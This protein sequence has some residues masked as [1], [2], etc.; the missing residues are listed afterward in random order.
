MNAVWLILVLAG[1]T[2]FTRSIGHIVV[3]QF[4]SLHPRV[5]AALDAVPAAV[6]TTIVIPPVVGGGLPERI[7]FLIAVMLALLL[8]IILTVSISVTVLALLRAYL[9][10]L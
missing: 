4:G 2:Y 1:V 9:G 3:A 7:A 8:P 6:I 5:Q 10:L